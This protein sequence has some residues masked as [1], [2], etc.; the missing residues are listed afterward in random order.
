MELIGQRIGKIVIK[1][2]LGHGGMGDVY[3]GYDETLKRRVAVKAIRTF[4]MDRAKVRARFLRE[5]QILSQLDFRHICRIYDY[6]E[7]GDE[8]KSDNTSFLI[9]EYIPGQN[10]KD[11]IERGLSRTDKL[12]IAI[13]IAEGL[14]E[15]HAK[16]IIHRDLKP[17]NV[18]ITPKKDVKILDFGVARALAMDE[19]LDDPVVTQPIHESWGTPAGEPNLTETGDLLGTPRYM[20]PEQALN[21]PVTAASDMYSFGLLLQELFTESP[22][23]PPNLA[24]L[25]LFSRAARGETEPIQGLDRE[26][27]SLIQSLLSRAPG[28]RPTAQVA[29]DALKRLLDRPKRLARRRANMIVM[30]LLLIG[31]VASSVGFYRASKARNAAMTSKADALRAAQSAREAQEEAEAVNRF[32]QNLLAS[33]DPQRMGMDV[34]V[35]DV[36][37]QAAKSVETDFEDH[38]ANKA[39]V[40]HSLAMTYLGLGRYDEAEQQI[41][42]AVDIRKQVY[43]MKH[44]QTLNACN[45]LAGILFYQGKYPELESVQQQVLKIA[46]ELYGP[47]HP[48]TIKNLDNLAIVH[49]AMDRFEDAER[50][51]RQALHMREQTLGPD[52][53]DTL[54]SAINLAVT[55]R[56]AER[57]EEAETLLSDLVPRMARVHGE[58]HPATLHALYLLASNALDLGSPDIAA[59]LAREC[60]AQRVK[61]LGPRHPHTLDSRMLWAEI[62]VQQKAY[63][64]A[65]PFLNDLTED[66]RDMTGEGYAKNLRSRSMLAYIADQQGHHDEAKAIWEEV[67]AIRRRDFPESRQA[68]LDLVCYLGENAVKRKAYDRARELLTEASEGY[69]A[70]L[71]AEHRKTREARNALTALPAQPTS[72]QDD[73]SLTHKDTGLTR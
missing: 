61:T 56:S 3:E 43:G 39:A 38:P 44:E 70:I 25:V 23:F 41:R 73:E 28:I 63:D 67:L 27:T 64:Q 31:A 51:H 10:L 12:K 16:N 42:A 15:A 35:V 5:A 29:R 9:L 40:H 4:G 47:D 53:E 72:S 49:N 71:G 59:P 57:F 55:L 21:E 2:M 54:R 34:R 69:E 65:I 62:L 11:A 52:H 37:D 60:L 1:D 24:P 22:P 18:M 46:M 58:H 26:L 48:T 8:E 33:A 32:L 19:P 7:P 14:N 66:T 45:A 68:L 36:L 6:L 20:S 13:Q 30:F 50:V 17:E